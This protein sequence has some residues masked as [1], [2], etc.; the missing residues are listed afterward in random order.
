[1]VQS[2]SQELLTPGTPIRNM[3]LYGLPI[4]HAVF[5]AMG[6]LLGSSVWKPL[7]ELSLE[8]LRSAYPGLLQGVPKRLSLRRSFILRAIWQWNGPISWVRVLLGTAV[9]VSG[10]IWTKSIIE[11]IVVMSEGKLRVVTQ[12]D[13]R[14]A[15]GEVFSLAILIGG[16]IAGS[17]SFNGLKQGLCVGI[18]ATFMLAGVFWNAA[19]GQPG[20]IVYP[21]LS[22]LCLGPVGGWFG[23]ELLP[24][25][26]QRVRRR[27]KAGWLSP[28]S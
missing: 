3:A 21:M 10:A 20:A 11:L 12:F 7:P 13:D 22:T 18:A 8:Q 19:A 9:A 23:S 5:G 24:P 1:L 6:G 16:C 25:V 26:Y 28:L 15:Y 17:N 2:F 27:K 14:M 4:L